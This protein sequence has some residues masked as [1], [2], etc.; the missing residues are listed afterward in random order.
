M[1]PGWSLAS[2]TSHGGVVSDLSVSAVSSTQSTQQSQWAQRKNLFDQLGQALQKGDLKGAQAAFAALQQNAP[3][4][5]AAQNGQGSGSGQS[6]FAALGQAL[7]SGDLAAAQQAYS[8]IQQ[9]GG[10]RHHH[11]GSQSNS[12]ATP[13]SA[14]AAASTTTAANGSGTQVGS[15]ATNSITQS[16][17]AQTKSLFDQ[18]GQALQNGDLKGAQAAFAALQQNAPQ[19]TSAQNG[20]GNG[21]GQSPFAALGQALQSGDLAAA[22]QAYSQIQQTGGHHHH[23]HGSQSNS[24]ATTTPAV[25]AASTTTAANGSGTLV[26]LTA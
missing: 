16:P 19:G 4:G 15:T 8:Q 5:T 20:Q 10:H 6:A 17:W 14:V 1:G 12:S 9:T 25:A 3:Q 26:N 21:S 7:Q 11:H 2:L 13:T 22:Q 24:S 18:L 23:H